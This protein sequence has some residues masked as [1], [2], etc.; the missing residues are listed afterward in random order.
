[1]L[2][3]VRTNQ[4]LTLK[5]SEG[6]TF[7]VERMVSV[8]ALKLAEPVDATS[9]G[10]TFQHKENDFVDFDRD[11][12]LY[13][14]MSSEGPRMSV[15][16]VNGDQLDDFYIGGAR[17]Q[18]GVLYVQNSNGTFRSTNEK[19]FEQ[20]KI[21]EDAGSVFFDADGDG[22]ADLYVC[23]GGN[24]FSPGSTAL[25]DRLYINDGKG[26]FS[27][28][29]QILPT[30]VFESTS[31][32]AASDYD[33]DGD[34]D[35]FVGVRMESML[36]GVAV[37]GYILNN[38]GHGKFKEVT[39][40]VA[41][42][43]KKV[44]M[45]TEGL[46]ADVD[47]DKDEDLVMVG[48]WMAVRIFYNEK[49]KLTEPTTAT[50]LEKSQGWWNSIRAADLDGDGD[51]DFVAGNHGLNSRFKASEAKPVT[52]Y[53]NDFDQN[54]TIE[55]IICTYNGEKSY[56]MALRHDLV[57][58]LPMLKKKYLKYSNYREQTITDVFTPEQMKGAITWT[59]NELRTSVIINQGQGR[60]EVRPL[61]MEAQFSPMYG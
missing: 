14:M 54:G 43:L 40:E 26:N 27:K 15:G 1:L 47:G 22:D 23:S 19:L 33:L 60:F 5:M 10:I 8:P 18:A 49:G 35:L 55:Q 45:I 13:H 56:P 29:P 3:H 31:T 24:E 61:P 2:T 50:G 36:Y 57:Q 53:V 38:D 34:M 32:V 46:W 51:M 59:C 48:D 11:R 6:N 58:Q 20:D 30:T 21:S 28:S 9:V 44:G 42:G 25:I 41:P 17:D 52:M 7:P 16:D 4:T 12:L 39:D 37:N